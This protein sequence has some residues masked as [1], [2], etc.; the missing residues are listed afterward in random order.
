MFLRIS[1]KEDSAMA[2]LLH[3]AALSEAESCR[4]VIFCIGGIYFFGN[5]YKNGAKKGSPH[6]QL[7]INPFV[8]KKM[9]GIKKE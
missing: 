3:M 1:E 6:N 2:Y 5:R 7:N 8:F 9:S 4:R